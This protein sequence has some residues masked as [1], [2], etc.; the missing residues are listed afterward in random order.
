MP[1][2]TPYTNDLGDRD[3]VATIPQSIDRIRALTGRWTPAEFERTY[4]P[5]K[6]SAR[7]I[8]VHLA[9][10]ELGLGNRARLAL[11]IPQYTAQPFDQD[12][13]LPL[14]AGMSGRQALDAFAA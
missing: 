14:D 12:R 1:P 8:L 2:I 11:T 9:Q 4:A 13:W 6:W 5:G 7:L 10:T 3:P